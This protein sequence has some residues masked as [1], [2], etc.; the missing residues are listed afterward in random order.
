M[1]EKERDKS[2]WYERVYKMRGVKDPTSI[3]VIF[4]LVDD[5]WGTVE[6][7]SH[8]R[9]Q[10]IVSEWRSKTRAIICCRALIF[11]LMSGAVCAAG[12]LSRCNISA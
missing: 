6:D 1:T 10:V 2:T 3:H 5:D 9:E 4:T 11:V 7:V 12:A 8:G